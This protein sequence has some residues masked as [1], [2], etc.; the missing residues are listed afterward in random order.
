MCAQICPEA[1]TGSSG[2]NVFVIIYENYQHPKLFNTNALI[3][4]KND[5]KH[6]DWAESSIFFAIQAAYSSCMYGFISASEDLED[7]SDPLTAYSNSRRP[8]FSPI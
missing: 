1:Q 3:H 7:D 2:S 4:P 6:F 8:R 5:E